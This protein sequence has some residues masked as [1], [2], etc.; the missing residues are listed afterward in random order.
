VI[1]VEGLIIDNLITVVVPPR[2]CGPILLGAIA[3]LA[4]CW[5]NLQSFY[6]NQLL[7]MPLFSPAQILFYKKNAQYLDLED[8]R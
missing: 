3:T 8:A 5:Q 4:G 6:R 7:I 1:L 2:L